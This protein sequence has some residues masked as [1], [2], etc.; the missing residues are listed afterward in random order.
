MME[1]IPIDKQLP[2]EEQELLNEETLWIMNLI[3]V[4]FDPNDRKVDWIIDGLSNS[5]KAIEAHRKNN[6]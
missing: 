5:V 4:Y 6:G 2:E 1:W 3:D